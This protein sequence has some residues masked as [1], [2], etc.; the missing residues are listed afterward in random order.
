VAPA[1]GRTVIASKLNLEEKDGIYPFA[2]VGSP[3]AAEHEI[4][5]VCSAQPKGGTHGKLEITS[6][7]G[8]W[9]VQGTHGGLAIDVSLAA[10]ASGAPVIKI[11]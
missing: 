10:T 11:A 2:E 4:L 5:T 1:A 9:R 6:S 7:A 3:E 8:Q